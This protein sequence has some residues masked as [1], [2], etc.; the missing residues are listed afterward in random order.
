MLPALPIVQL[1]DDRG[2]TLPTARG[3][4]LG[5][6][7]GPVMVP[8][9]LAAGHRVFTDLR[10]VS[11][12]VFAHNRSVRAASVLVRIGS[13]TLRAPLA[14]VVFAD[15]GKPISFDQTPLRAVEGMAAG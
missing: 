13:G 14:V 6:Q 1:R 12:P 10:W 3:R 5:M 4:S 9:R 7:P 15:R 2:R 8:V 11:G